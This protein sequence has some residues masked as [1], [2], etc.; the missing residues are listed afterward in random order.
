MGEGNYLVFLTADHGAA[1]NFKFM[2]DHKL[3]A[4]AWNR[5]KEIAPLL[6]Q[7]LKEKLGVGLQV[8]SGFLAYRLYLNKKYISE[9]GLDEAKIRKTIVDFLKTAYHVQFVADMEQIQY[10][11]IPDIIRS[12]ALMGYHP[13][14]SGDILVVPETGWYEFG[15]WSSPI[16]T[17]HGEWNPYDAHSPLLF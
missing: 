11:S 2:E 15:R 10:A 17:S 3:A 13:R 4:G 8:I 12:R 6:E 16:G 9:Q 5:E 14:R 1:H 7:E